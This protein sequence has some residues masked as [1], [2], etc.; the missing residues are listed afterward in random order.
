MGLLMRVCRA[1]DASGPI[2][3]CHISTSEAD[4]HLDL[5]FD[6]DNTCVSHSYSHPYIYTPFSLSSIA[7]Y[8]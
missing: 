5:P 7:L 1:E 4:P 3:T 8:R 2:T 6:P